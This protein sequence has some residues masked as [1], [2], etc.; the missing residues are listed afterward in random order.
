MVDENLIR[1]IIFDFQ[2]QKSPEFTRRTVN[3][4]CPSNKI[5]TIIGGRRV[6]KTYSFYQIMHDLISQGV[7]K[8]Q[9]L[10]INFEDER[11]I[12]IEV[13]DLSKIYDTF[14]EIYPENKDRLTYIF[15]DEIQN[16]HNWERFIRRIH[17]TENVQINLT[18]SSAKLLSQE[19]A[20][21]LRGRTLTFEIYP[22]SFSEYLDHKKIKTKSR[23][24]KNRAYIINAFHR[25]LKAGGYPE[26]LDVEDSFRIMILQDYFNLV[27]YKDLVER[28]NIRNYALMKY[29]LRHLLVNSANPFSV[30]KVYSDLKSQGYKVSKDALHN[31]FAY[32]E[33]AFAYLWC[34][35]FQLQFESNKLIIKKYTVLIMEW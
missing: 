11:L 35:S 5:R 14:F 28:Y 10:F 20:T 17:D 24:S 23:S 7:L 34:Q 6:G 19:I 33:E 31:Y 30:N 9:F 26:T 3:L 2:E 8:E 15:F 4:E 27:L 1:E 13:S 25:Y 18:G 16:V 22:F 32:L 21:S 12:Q 29:L